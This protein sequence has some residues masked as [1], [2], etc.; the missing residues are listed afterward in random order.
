MTAA[1]ELDA[2]IDEALPAATELSVCVRDR[3]ATGVHAVLGPVLDTGD[4][5]QVAA[6][7]IALAVMIPDDLPFGDLVAWTHGPHVSQEAYAEIVNLVRPGH[8]RCSACREV[9]P[10]SEFR[11]DRRKRDGHKSRCCS[12]LSTASRSTV[13]RREGAA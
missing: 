8:K 10:L 3:D 7:I 4:R 9:Q 13:G 1:H 12:C 6:L 11:R 2:L 5:D